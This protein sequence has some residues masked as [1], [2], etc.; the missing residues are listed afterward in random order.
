MRSVIT[1]C[2]HSAA[3]PAE[4]AEPKASNYPHQHLVTNLQRFMRY[5][6]AAYGQA[7]L[8]ILGIGR[9]DFNFPNTQTRSFSFL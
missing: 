1:T 4:E 9:H 6:S 3:S 5:S 2:T 8:R 7:F